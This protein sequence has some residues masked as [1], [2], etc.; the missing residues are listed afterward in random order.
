MIKKTDTPVQASRVIADLNDLT[1]FGYEG[2]E[3]GVNRPSFSP[4]YREA[5]DWLCA[6]MENAGLTVRM[7][8]VGN[9]IGR[10][11]PADK[12]AVVCGHT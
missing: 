8:A 5:A 3:K 12:P 6:R 2:D 1:K 4:A 11:G 7:D 10:A 9:I